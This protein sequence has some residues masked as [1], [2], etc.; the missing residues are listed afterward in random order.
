MGKTKL[1]SHIIKQHNVSGKKKDK[2]TSK[3]CE[4]IIP[5]YLINSKVSDQM[6]FYIETICTD[7]TSAK[8]AFKQFMDCCYL[9]IN[10]DELT[11]FEKKKFSRSFENKVHQYKKK[12]ALRSIIIPP[13]LP[14]LIH[15]SEL[16]CILER[17]LVGYAIPF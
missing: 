17:R 8:S 12:L 9:F 7:F 16:D 3:Q 10:P 15:E 4:H 5:R 13:N 11:E 14:K 2:N 6:N 1:L